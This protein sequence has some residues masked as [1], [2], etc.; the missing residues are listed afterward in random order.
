MRRTEAELRASGIA[1]TSAPG[2]LGVLA[3][4]TPQQRQIVRL[5]RDGLTNREIADQLHLS[6][7]TIKE[8][9]SEVMDK[10]GCGTVWSWPSGPRRTRMQ[11]SAA[12]RSNGHAHKS[13]GSN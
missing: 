5:A 12:R 1:V 2:A 11:Y 6:V 3:E 7:N 13:T 9:M 8:Y 4:L 10:L